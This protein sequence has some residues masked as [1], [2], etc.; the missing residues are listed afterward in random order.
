LVRPGKTQSDPAR[1]G[2]SIDE[3][4]FNPVADFKTVVGGYG[5]IASIKEFVDVRSKENSILDPV[6]SLPLIISRV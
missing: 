2:K 1:D 6:L 5:D 4:F 3:F